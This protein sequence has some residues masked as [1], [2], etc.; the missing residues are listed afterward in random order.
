[1]PKHK[2]LIVEDDRSIAEVLDYNLTNSGYD[3]IVTSDGRNA[4]THARLKI[5]DLVIL[6]LMLPVLDGLSVCKNLRADSATRDIPVLMLTAKGEET[7]QLVGFA[8]G[9]DDYVVK[10]FS[11]KI[12]LERV[13]SLLRRRGQQSNGKA[14]ICTRGGLTVD[15]V[16]HQVSLDGQEIELTPSEFR[17]LDTLIRQPGRAFDRGDRRAQH[18]ASCERD[19][20]KQQG[21][22]FRFHGSPRKL[23]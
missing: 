23:E 9:A 15:R 21:G 3:T 1:M 2:I 8:L 6:D 19:R 20:G 14:E 22:K 12:V 4:L 17:L 5:P 10:P 16:K 11:V 13:K 7:D 18:I